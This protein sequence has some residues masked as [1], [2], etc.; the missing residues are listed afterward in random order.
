MAERAELV[1]M[2]KAFKV[3]ELTTLLTF[4]GRSKHGLKQ[5][6]QIRAL[7]LLKL[8]S[9]PI[10]MKIK[11]IYNERHRR[12]QQVPPA[13]P[14]P[15][16]Y[17]PPALS[18]LPEQ[19]A[20]AYESY[21][22]G[23][24]APTVRTNIVTT[25]LPVLPDVRLKP[26]PFYEHIAELLKPSTLMPVGGALVQEHEFP[27]YLTPAQVNE[28]AYYRN[29][30]MSNGEHVVEVQMRFCRFEN[31]CEQ[32]DC[33][34]NDVYVKV[35]T[36]PCALPPLLPSNQSKEKRRMPY[37]V[38]ITP[39]VILNATIAN[40]VKIKWAIEA[41]Q[42]YVT[43]INLVKKLSASDLIK[44]LRNRGIRPAES[45]RSL[46]KE[47]L[48]EDADSEVATTSLRVSLMCPLGQMRIV[49]PCRPTTCTHLQCFDARVYIQ[50]N[51]RKS[52]WTCPVCSKPGDF[53]K[54]FIDGYFH[55]VLNSDKL[56]LDV[57]E[58]EL[59]Q[60]GSWIFVKEE[61]LENT[62]SA[63]AKN[64][65]GPPVLMEV[66]EITD[67]DIVPLD[68]SSDSE[69]IK[70]KPMQPMQVANALTV[71]L[72]ASDDDDDINTLAPVNIN[73]PYN[74]TDIDKVGFGSM[75]PNL[76]IQDIIDLDSP[77]NSPLGSSGE[78]QFPMKTAPVQWDAAP[79]AQ[80]QNQTLPSFFNTEPN[81][82]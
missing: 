26:L 47:K 4:A 55:E 31:T 67:D 44:K 11:E 57:N 22:N 52:T 19:M 72:T 35:N 2:V 69:D 49:V 10:Q 28:L 58:V 17:G 9:V 59:L 73:T 30:E 3:T 1:K 50:M 77:P 78:P 40:G 76:L 8:N 51:E 13:T 33:L 12:T 68:V 21:T 56:P 37:P 79:T 71:D 46:V 54:L 75:R 65:K 7:E 25:N 24:N 14:Q 66:L 62:S 27:F 15:S 6:M 38:N 60:D 23:N 63:A 34:P 45:T 74:K 61:I 42:G 36:K 70:T 43:A 39:H 5:E 16:L 29:A 80:C 20:R 53:D 48:R 82:P 64:R 81:I 41:D 32:D 18:Y